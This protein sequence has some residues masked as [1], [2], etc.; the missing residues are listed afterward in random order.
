MDETNSERSL[1]TDA[2][3][4]AIL[5]AA[6]QSFATKGFTQTTMEDIRQLSG[7][8]MGSIYHHFNNKEM[9]AYALFLEGRGELNAALQAA[10]VEATPQEGIQALVRAYLDWFAAHPDLGQYI[11]QAGTT[12]FLGAY[13]RVLRQKTLT[14]LPLETFRQELYEWLV[15][16]IEAGIVRRLPAWL[17]FPLVIGPAREFVRR[18]VRSPEP[19]EMA[20][21]KEP[22]ATSAW[23]VLRSEGA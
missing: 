23:I 11:L 8:S 5:Q 18:W 10:L 9:L 15:P 3:R 2:R 6:L 17:Y 16:A 4:R 20:A 1:A 19:A 7:A 22:L 13:V 14:P 12:E 21:A